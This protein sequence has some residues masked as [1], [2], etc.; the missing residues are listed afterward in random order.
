MTRSYSYASSCVTHD[1]FKVASH[2]AHDSFIRVHIIQIDWYVAHDLF[3]VLLLWDV[4]YSYV[5][6]SF[7]YSH[8]MM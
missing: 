6:N 8:I 2:V 7:V 1:S 4:T 5:C 3:K